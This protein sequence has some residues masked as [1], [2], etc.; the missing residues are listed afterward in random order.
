MAFA[1]YRWL[2]LA[3]MFL[4]LVVGVILWFVPAP[5]GRYGKSGWG[6]QLDPKLA[7]TLMEAPAPIIVGLA[8]LLRAPNWSL[9]QIVLVLLWEWH[10]VYRAFLYPRR[11]KGRSTM[12][13]A[14]VAMAFLFNI[15]NGT[16][17]CYGLF[18]D[19]AVRT[20][21]HLDSPVFLIGVVLYVVGLLTNRQAHRLLREMRAQAREPYVI[22]SGG[23][24]ERVSS[25][26]YLGEILQWIGWALATWSLAGLSFA[27]WTA[28]NLVPRARLNHRWY[29]DTFSDYPPERRILIPFVW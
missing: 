8:F 5:Y 6:P 2:S 17:Q 1:L 23:L 13:A 15:V 16:L 20:G 9:V 14:V 29:R 28:A 11:L 18:G 22:P 4:A 24:Y 25:P 12:P 26:N 3:W 21:I 27:I 19:A 10:Y 7:W